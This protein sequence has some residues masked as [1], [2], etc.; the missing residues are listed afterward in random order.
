MV[1]PMKDS[2]EESTAT[3]WPRSQKFRLSA[4]GVV[5]GAAY[6]EQVAAARADSGRASFDKA[7]NAWASPLRLKPEDGACLIELESGPRTIADMA[8]A[9]DACGTSAGEVKAAM[10]RLLAALMIEPVPRPEVFR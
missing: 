6:L 2:L 7:R 9:L 8:E 5:A 4:M 3:R 10:K 1:G